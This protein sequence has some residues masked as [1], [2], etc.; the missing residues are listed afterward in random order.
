MKLLL[1]LFLCRLRISTSFLV[2]NNAIFHQN[3]DK[4]ELMVV[5][6]RNKNL[7]NNN[8]VLAEWSVHQRNHY[9]VNHWLEAAVQASQLACRLL[10]KKL[11]FMRK[12]AGPSWWVHGMSALAHVHSM[13]L[14]ALEDGYIYS[15][16]VEF[17][18]S[19]LPPVV[20]IH[21]WLLSAS[22]IFGEINF[23]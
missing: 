23:F 11:M 19:T 20:I 17:F 9:A 15:R 16:F 22:T 2:I 13:H 10:M 4:K 1:V 6:T 21:I 3:S 14:R 8:L 18:D 7:L 5:N 12:V